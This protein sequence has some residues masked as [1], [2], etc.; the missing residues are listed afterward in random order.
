MTRRA[1]R[2][3][4]V[5]E[6]SWPDRPGDPPI[7]ADSGFGGSAPAHGK[8]SLIGWVDDGSGPEFPYLL[9]L[10]LTLV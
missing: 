1:V 5:S 3:A 8:S 6:E 10:E 4:M 9:F 7:T 2:A